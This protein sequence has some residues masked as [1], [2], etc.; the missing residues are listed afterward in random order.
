MTQAEE[1]NK[2]SKWQERGAVN[3]NS[4]FHAPWLDPVFYL[5]QTSTY[6]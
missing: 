3:T 2:M 5:T 4:K 6:E 1:E